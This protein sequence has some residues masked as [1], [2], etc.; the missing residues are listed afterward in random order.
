M[1]GDPIT[2]IFGHG[3]EITWLAA[4]LMTGIFLFS[5]IVNKKPKK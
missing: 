4:G 5:I 2:Y 3:D 1:D